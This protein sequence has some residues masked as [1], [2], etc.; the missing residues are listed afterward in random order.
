LQIDRREF[1]RIA[2]A[3]SILAAARPLGA[4]AVPRFHFSVML[5]ALDKIA[6][7]EKSIESVAQAGYDGI[8]L[9]S[10]YRKWTDADFTRVTARLKTLNLVVDSMAGMKNGFADAATLDA[11]LSELATGI[12]AAKR[13]GCRQIILVSRQATASAN[14]RAACIENLKRITDLAAK[15]DIEIV[16][17]PIDLLEN[18]KS[19]MTS[20]VDA[21]EIARAINHPKL[22]V[23]YDVYHEQRQ[24]GNLLEKFEN[25]MDLITL[26][27]IADVP[28]RHQPGTGE[29]RYDAIY[30]KL[31]ELKYDRF[32]AME[33]YPTG[34]VVENLR[35][36]RLQAIRA[37]G[38]A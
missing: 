1:G 4:Q 18:P 17:E 14:P 30:Q 31:A 3:T 10:E 38:R 6:P 24:A 7:T 32:I 16:I 23:L 20:V 21:F 11:L 9:V 8:E 25:N 35:A 26:I 13:L 33:F 27:H 22:R 36:A 37:A 2:A 28:G 34:D 29:I 12:T 19:Y 5:W 15:T